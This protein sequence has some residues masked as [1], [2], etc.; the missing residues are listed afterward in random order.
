MTP[1]QRY[2]AE[3]IAV[4]HADGLLS[5]REALRRLALLGLGLTAASSLLAACSGNRNEAPSATSAPT[6]PGGAPPGAAGAVATEPITF[7]GPQ[8][9]TLQ[10]AWAAAA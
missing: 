6:S 9:R 8:G 4:D 5:R 10:G 3:E 1:L 2:I 7:P